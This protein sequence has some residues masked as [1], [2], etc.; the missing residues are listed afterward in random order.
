[1]DVVLEVDLGLPDTS[2]LLFFET[3][4]DCGC[5]DADLGLADS[6][7]FSLSCCCLQVVHLSPVCRSISAQLVWLHVSLISS[8]HTRMG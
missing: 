8:Q 2:C 1:M 4:A 3:W 6:L 5:C 7:V